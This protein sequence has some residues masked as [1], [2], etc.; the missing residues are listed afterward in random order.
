MEPLQGWG[1]GEGRNRLKGRCCDWWR[2][3]PCAGEVSRRSF[4]REKL[5]RSDRTFK[6][7]ESCSPKCWY[8]STLSALSLRWRERC[9][10]VRF[11]KWSPWKHQCGYSV[12]MQA[13]ASQ[14]AKMSRL[15]NV[16]M[17]RTS[18]E[19]ALTLLIIGLLDNY[20]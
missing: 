8:N 7:L 13:I 6:H 11:Q 5:H 18:I 2:R 1:F 4:E 16:R 9:E 20:W 3:D 17:G 12:A 14:I 19:A 15:K 10:V